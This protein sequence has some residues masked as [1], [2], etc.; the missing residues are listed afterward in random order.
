MPT[1]CALRTLAGPG[2]QECPQESG[3]PSEPAQRPGRT[4]AVAWGSGAQ[5]SV[6]SGA[7]AQDS[8]GVG[9]QVAAT[10]PRGAFP[11]GLLAVTAT[12]DLPQ[13]HTAVIDPLPSP[14]AR[15]AWLNGRG[16]AQTPAGAAAA[17]ALEVVCLLLDTAFV[18]A[19][20][21]PWPPETLQL[22]QARTI[23]Q[24]GCWGPGGG[25]AGG[26]SRGHS[27]TPGG[28]VLGP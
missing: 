11:G 5:E 15:P 7:A 21:T 3:R 28:T 2:G 26:L 23:L 13:T 18:S 6:S 16:A 1:G 24:L 10:C 4:P 12:H 8:G 20:R 9:T 17:S 25:W 19:E 27:G 22:S 14:A